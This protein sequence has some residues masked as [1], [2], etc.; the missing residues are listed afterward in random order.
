MIFEPPRHGKSE[1][2]SRRTPALLHGMYPDDEIMAASYNDSLAG[3]MCVDVQNI[4]DSKEYQELF[5]GTKIPLQGLS[6]TKGKRNSEEHHIIGR[7][8]K[9]RGQG[10]GGSFTG[11]GANWV[12]IDD[13]IK[14]REIA[15]SVAFRE[16]L[17][18]FWLNDLYSRLETDLESGR[19]GKVL[20][21]LTRWHEDDLA[22][23]LIDLMRKNPK[24]MQFE[25][26]KYPAIRVDN[27][28]TT[29]PREV[30]EALWPKKYNLQQLE[31][32]RTSHTEEGGMRS[33][34]S[35]Y[36]QDPIPDG[37][38]LFTEDMF[39]FTD[40]PGGYD[41]TF[42][43]MDTSYKEKQENDFTVCSVWGVRSH[44]RQHQIY[45]LDC[46]RKQMKAT[47]VEHAIDPF[48][49]PYIQYGYRGTWIEPKGHGIY[50]NQLWSTKGKMMIPREQERLDFFKD[51]SFDKVQRAS[52]VAP[53]LANRK[54]YINKAL[55]NKEILVSEAL[56]FPKGKFDDFVDTLVDALKM[57][58]CRK[59]GIL[60]TV[61]V[62]R[63]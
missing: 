36:Q 55:A 62:R 16:R 39:E 13:P 5:P 20:I 59:V 63:T 24:A 34:S 50:L 41:Y 47:E 52:N 27:D 46:Y 31:E 8:G 3:D 30:G 28:D 2:V 37:G 14:G 21:T 18:N 45:L 7:R 29:D 9:Y 22:G 35:L 12:I 6:Y 4:I 48:L 19:T 54:V 56:I 61:S 53:H 23:R 10:V 44:A 26:V 51:R 38:G 49:L 33:W 42:S 25:M 15:D 32:I 40:L 17:W 58:Y 60:D 57:V 11:K 43:T 1:L